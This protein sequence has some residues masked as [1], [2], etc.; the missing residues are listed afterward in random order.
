MVVLTGIYDQERLKQM[1]ARSDSNFYLVNS[2]NIYAT[3]MVLWYRFPTSYLARRCKVD[4]VLV[5][6]IIHIPNIPPEHLV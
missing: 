1:L 2:R 4:I 5:P 3:Q 6:G